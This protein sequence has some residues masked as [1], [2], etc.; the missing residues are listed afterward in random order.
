MLLITHVAN[1]CSLVTSVRK[2]NNAR[3]ADKRDTHSEV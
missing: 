1:M 2:M 3:E